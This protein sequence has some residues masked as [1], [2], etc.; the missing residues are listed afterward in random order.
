MLTKEDLKDKCLVY[1]EDITEDVY[2]KIIAKLKSIGIPK[3]TGIDN[4]YKGFKHHGTLV[5][6]YS[7]FEYNTAPYIILNTIF[8][9][10]IL[11]E[12]WDK[13]DNNGIPKAKYKVGDLLEI[14]K[15]GYQ[16]N[17]NNIDSKD[18]ITYMKSDNNVQTNI[19]T[20]VTYSKTNKI[21]F[22]KLGDYQNM[23][24]ETGVKLQKDTPLFKKGDLVIADHPNPCWW[25]KGEILKLGGKFFKKRN[26]YN[27]QNE[28]AA[29]CKKYPNGGGN[30]GQEGKNNVRHCTTDEIAYY[31]KVGIGANI[32]DMK[33]LKE[34]KLNDWVVII[35]NGSSRNKIGDIGQITEISPSN[36]SYRVTVKNKE[37]GG[38]WQQLK[39]IRHATIKEI[40]NKELLE[41]AIKEYPI[42]T[43]FNSAITPS[44][45]DTYTVKT[46]NH[47][48][49]EDGCIYKDDITGAT[50]YHAKEQRWANIVKKPNKV[51][52]VDVLIDEA[53]TRYP[54]GTKFYPAHLNQ[55]SYYCIVTNTNFKLFGDN[56]I[57]ATTDEKLSFD[58]DSKYGN[59]CYYNR[60]VYYRGKWAK[61][62]IDEA[63]DE[64]TA[65]HC[66][67]QEEWDFV[68]MK[69]KYDWEKGSFNFYKNNSVIYLKRNTYA[70]VDYANRNK[71]RLL[72][73]NDWLKENNYTIEKVNPYLKSQSEYVKIKGFKRLKVEII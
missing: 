8:V 37:G 72:S 40:A 60:N 44:S 45:N 39:E 18:A 69:L 41:K 35:K 55:N 2:N 70:C 49:D 46:G 43:E 64:N 65:V 36:K 52:S 22:Y 11:G 15:G 58:S 13:P 50:I 7:F 32:N 53:I 66:T 21:W 56:N 34:F 14:I 24:T 12:D 63:T 25:E 57:S 19:C 20:K 48:L 26:I 1:T 68:T 5:F 30:N 4:D 33:T 10:D 29:I 67:T 54:I 31:N 9:K 71:H 73:F 27:I 47:I 17:E 28:I 62:V 38:N 51:E 59:K 61:I 23:I 42:G 3:G 16:Y 6:N